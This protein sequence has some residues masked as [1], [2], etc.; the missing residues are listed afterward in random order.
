[1]DEIVVEKDSD[2]YGLSDT[3]EE[4]SP[5]LNVH[6]A[7]SD[8]DGEPDGL[9]DKNRNGVLNANE[10]DPRE[11]DAPMDVR[12][13]GVEE[14]K[15]NDLSDTGEA[16]SAPWDADNDGYGDYDEMWAG[17]NAW[18]KRRRRPLYA[19]TPPAN[20]IPASTPTGRCDVWLARGVSIRLMWR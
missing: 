13:D 14:A 4:A 8:N 17:Y 19:T 18:I 16:D 10:T 2:R 15:R 6:D 9:E 5:C 11:W 1:M 20:V 3:V 7:D 12:S